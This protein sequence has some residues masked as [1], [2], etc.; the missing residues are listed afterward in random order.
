MKATNSKLVKT[1][2]EENNDICNYQL[3][4]NFSDLSDDRTNPGTAK[5]R[6]YNTPKSE[7]EKR[8][9]SKKRSNSKTKSRK[10]S[11]DST[12]TN[13]NNLIELVDS[14]KE[15]L[16]VYENEMR[17]LIEQKVQMQIQINTLQLNSY[18]NLKK[19]GKLK[20]S[21][22]MTHSNDSI[23]ELRSFQETNNGLRNELNNM[24]NQLTKQ[25][26]LLDQ[27]FSILN[28]SIIPDSIFKSNVLSL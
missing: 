12:R 23:S 9:K 20:K 7:K 26:K 28:D 1:S 2:F 10:N 11:I 17:C 5:S 15:K 14:L 25:R 19:S 4:H 18:Q 21:G 3:G 24:N 8:E 22:D 6:N 16:S 27:N 13:N